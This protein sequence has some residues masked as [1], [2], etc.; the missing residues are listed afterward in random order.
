METR[1]KIF[2]K[3]GFL[4]I[5]FT[6]LFAII[7]GVFILFLAIFA[8]TKIMETGQTAISAKGAKE[9][10][11]L[12]NP[13]ETGFETAKS[14]FIVLPVES[15]I[16]NQCD[17]YGT[18]GRQIIELSQKS[19]DKWV[20]TDVEVSFQ[21]KYIFSEK[22]IEG[23]KF[24]LFSKPFEFPFK[25]S[26]LVYI[27]SSE[28]EYCFIDAPEEIEDEVSSLNQANLLVKNCS[29]NSIKVC[30]SGG[31]CSIDVDYGNKYVKKNG[32]RMYFEGDSL[33]YS[34]IFSDKKVY[35][36]QLKRLMKR[37]EQLSL[38]Y[39]NKL[40]FVERVGCHS[41]LKPDLLEFGS[42]TKK[43]ES[44][45]N[46]GYIAKVAEEI[47]DKNELAECRLW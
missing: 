15:R 23:K 13:L 43:L 7:V 31:S 45:G 17:D 37:A 21:N 44:S 38:L 1:K 2:R 14:T 6:W 27:T 30:F 46:M 5:S 40:E 29:A 26:D 35:E 18:F 10:G 34:A 32:E 11:I 16:Y 3:G 8:V 47:N 12:L 42:L 24:Y 33:M 20:D 39:I 25:I 28:N 19:F 9:I 22:Y 4:D 36:C 41:N